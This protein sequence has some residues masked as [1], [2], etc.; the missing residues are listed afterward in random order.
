MVCG[1]ESLIKTFPDEF[2]RWLVQ[3]GRV[4][5]AKKVL[6]RLRRKGDAVEKVAAKKFSWDLTPGTHVGVARDWGHGGR[7]QEDPG[8]HRW[9]CL[10]VVDH[11]SVASHHTVFLLS[12]AWKDSNVRKALL[13]GCS[14]Q[15]FQQLIGINTV[16]FQEHPS[17]CNPWLAGDLLL[18]KDPHDVRHLQGHDHDP[19]AVSP[20]LCRQLF[21]LLS[22][23]RS[24]IMISFWAPQCFVR[25]GSDWQAWT[26]SS[27]SQLLHWN[28]CI[29]SRHRGWISTFR[30]WI[31]HFHPKNN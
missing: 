6:E 18:C 10:Q 15:L 11:H 9:Q 14:L 2:S 19:L 16:R 12:R 26:E 3:V 7:G 29:T 31:F 30:V 20:G 28:P 27:L 23:C 17:C 22:R 4:E 13:V 25:D 5:E 21:C 1:L 8:H 24:L